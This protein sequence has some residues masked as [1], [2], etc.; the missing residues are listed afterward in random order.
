MNI[1]PLL[2][3]AAVIIY[4]LNRIINALFKDVNHPELRQ[5]IIDAD[6][7]PLIPDYVPAADADN[8][9]Q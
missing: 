9:Q 6:S 8:T 5:A 2:I 1:L 7:E 3:V 4:F